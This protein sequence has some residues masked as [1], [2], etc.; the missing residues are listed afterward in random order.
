NIYKAVT[1]LKI[2][3]PQGNI[4][5]SPL[6]PEFQ[7]FGSDR[8]IANEIEI[9]KS[10]NLR[11]RVAA[12]LI[13]SFAAS[14]NADSFYL[15]IDDDSNFGKNK[16]E[17]R[18]IPSLAKLLES[19]VAIDQKRG[20]DIVE[21]SAESPSPVEA[22]LVANIYAQEY[23]NF[24]LEISRNLLT[25]VK[26]FLQQQKVEKQTQLNQAEETLRSFQEK[27]GVIALDEQA[28]SLIQ[29]L[30]Q[31]EAQKNA[32]LIEIEAS[33][34]MLNQYKAELEKQ[35]PRLADYLEGLKSE[36]YFKSL[37][38]QLAKMETN[39]D[40]ALSSE[41]S[42]L[43]KSEVV[44]QYDKKINELKQKL[45]EK[46][47]VI[48][49]SIFASSPE[50]VKELSQKII[51]EE[52][53]NQTLRV[54]IT[55][56][57]KIVNQYDKKFNQ[58]PKT[59]IELAR[60]QR[61]RES[62]EKLYTLVEEKYQEALINEQS[63]PGNVLIID[64]ALSPL[65][66]SKPNR[67]FIILVGFV[68]GFGLAFGYVFIK[69]YFDN[70]VKTPDDIQNRNIN[71]LT[72]IPT[73]EWLGG[74]NGHKESE[75]IIAAKPDSVPSEAFRA[76]RTR[77]Q[78]SRLGENAIKTI[79]VT[80]SAPQEGK[81]IISVNL[82]GSFAQSNKKVLLLDCDLRKPRV[83]SVFN[84]KRFPG[85][86]DY[87]FGHATLNEIINK[88]DLPN[89]HYITAGTIPPNPAEMLESKEMKNFLK[90][91][92]EVYDIIVLDS[93]PIVAVTDAEV[94]SRMVDAVILVVSSE[95]TEV[96]LMQKSVDLLRNESNS[97]IGTVLNNFTYKY[98]YGSYY[99]YYYYYSHPDQKKEKNFFKIS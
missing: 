29:Q 23:K 84:T 37:Q 57:A 53:R 92:K 90:E 38:D 82:A 59:T 66:P 50:E 24:N 87:L 62:L 6:M 42:K 44:K 30:S 77:V 4:L 3:K 68:M 49:S 61:Q 16:K 2:S 94:L 76:L 17:V 51:E 25:N 28:T 19:K 56:L 22:A 10:Y 69:N 45:N 97:F 9:L 91:M 13:D 75:F 60:F 63:Q 64:D 98:G 39:R 74:S 27:G 11:E 47:D 48:K 96:E 12:S 20:L 81:T 54:T 43:N 89:M 79:L 65:G 88:T 85:V 7:D 58:L 46:I 35:N 36:A 14:S 1:M 80:S 83:H 21:I 34:K 31:F 73:I 70:T 78:F 71:V 32:A 40:L 52:I 95:T 33:N 55:E 41:E 8:F 5:E 26:D 86:I 72:W 99:K 93:P 15:I 18:T 67:I